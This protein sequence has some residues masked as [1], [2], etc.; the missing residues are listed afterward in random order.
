MMAFLPAYSISGSLNK[1]GG[2]NDAEPNGRVLHASVIDGTNPMF[3]AG[4]G[5]SRKTYG[6]EVHIATSAKVL[7][8]YSAG[9]GVKLFFGSESRQSAHD[10][11]LSSLGQPLSWLQT[12]ITVDNLIEANQGKA[13]GRYREVTL[14]IKANIQKLLYLYF[15]P[16]LVPNKPGSQYGYQA[17]A[18]IPVMNDFFLRGGVSRNSNQPHLGIYG[19]GYGFGFGWIFPRISV[20]FAIEKSV[21][22][23][24]TSGMLFSLTII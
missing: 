8:Q 24:E 21:S 1:F 12:G 7:P 23:V 17:G 9:V 15:D 3:Q 5:Y 13:W 11:T 18:E 20:D 4:V 10:V 22:P 14:G 2:P 19:K 6:R 16:H